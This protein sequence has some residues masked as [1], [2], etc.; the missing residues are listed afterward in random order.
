MNKKIHFEIKI[1]HENTWQI[2]GINSFLSPMHLAFLLNKN[3]DLRFCFDPLT[4]A[5]NRWIY[6]SETVEENF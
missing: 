1:D 6:K 2:W 3:L 4:E 5:E